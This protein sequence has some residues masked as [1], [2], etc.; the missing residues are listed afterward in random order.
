MAKRGRP[1]K[2]G[3]V[4]TIKLILN[5]NQL[6]WIKARKQSE[7]VINWINQA[8]NA[9]QL[10]PAIAEAVRVAI[11]KSQI[12]G[13][14]FVVSYNTRYLERRFNPPEKKY[15]SFISTGVEN[16]AKK[17]RIIPINGASFVFLGKQPYDD[18][19]SGESEYYLVNCA[20][21]YVIVK[22]VD[23]GEYNFEYIDLTR[24]PNWML[25]KLGEPKI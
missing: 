24:V 19:F 5:K 9:E 1:S 14:D 7:L 18:G 3:E 8:M 15:H 23:Q 16:K 22:D 6:S 20:E 13:I 2:D 10:H 25:A 4:H 11:A 21:P 12:S 17:S